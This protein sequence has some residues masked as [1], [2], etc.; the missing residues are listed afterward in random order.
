MPRKPRVRPRA[1]GSPAAQATPTGKRIHQCMRCGA[2]VDPAYGAG[3]GSWCPACDAMD[4]TAWEFG[5]IPF[6]ALY[7]AWLDRQREK[8]AATSARAPDAPPSISVLTSPG[9][10]NMKHAKTHTGTYSCLNCCVDYDL[11]AET[12]LKCDEC[13]AAL[14]RGTLDELCEDDDGEE[15]A[16]RPV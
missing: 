1:G 9:G 14:L 11:V 15:T 7:G 12:H 13:G 4:S 8:G 16:D 5:K 6:P 10:A 2:L 3:D